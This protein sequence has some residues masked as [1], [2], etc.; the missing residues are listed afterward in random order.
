MSRL[1]LNVI[2]LSP[3]CFIFS[4]SLIL[5][6]LFFMIQSFRTFGAPV[7][8]GLD[9]IG[10]TKLEYRFK[11]E[12]LAKSSV[13]LNSETVQN[14]LKS[15]GLGSSQAMISKDADPVL[16]LRSRAISDDPIAETLASELR[17][18]YGDFEIKSIDTVSPIIGPELFRSGLTAL[19][20]T[21]VAIVLYVSSR[22]RPDYAACA[23]IALV[24]D[25]TIVVGL[26][27]YLGLYQ[28]IEVDMMFITA[29]LTVF[30][31]SI[32]DTIV[33]FDRIRE[34]QKLENKNFNFDAVADLSINQVAA[35]SLA[36][37]STALIVLAILFFYGGEST[38]I[39]AAAMF[40]GMFIGTY[41][42]IFLASPLLVICRRQGLLR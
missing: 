3:L 37:S 17:A 20:L 35:R 1:N 15:I 40:V 16:I 5:A 29:L 4:G 30:G 11:A 28:G 23:I 14:L 34:N 13:P 32:H 19:L 39:F 10:G 22:F 27:A 6:S 42:S 31:F 38:K 25:V 33:V 7:R 24:H 26:F 12:S 9:F 2:K 21:I 8:P 36:T 18:H 41:S